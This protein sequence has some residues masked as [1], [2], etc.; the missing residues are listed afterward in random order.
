MANETAIIDATGGV[1]AVANGGFNAGLDKF[2]SVAIPLAVFGMFGFMI[3]NAS[4]HS[5]NC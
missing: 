2:L 1:V 4:K 5:K 3:Y